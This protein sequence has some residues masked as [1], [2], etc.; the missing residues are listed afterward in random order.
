MLYALS[1]TVKPNA[2][3]W[4]AHTSGGVNCETG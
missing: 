4:L 2:A 1:D 3:N